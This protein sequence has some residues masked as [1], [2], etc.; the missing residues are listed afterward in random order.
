MRL[1]EFIQPKTITEALKLQS[2]EDMRQVYDFIIE[3][4]SVF[5]NE[6][7]SV[8]KLLYRG[9]QYDKNPKGFISQ[10]K[11]RQQT[12]SGDRITGLIDEYLKEQGFIA[13]RSN[14][15]F[16]TSDTWMVSDFG[17]KYAIFP[18]NNSAFTWSPTCKDLP[19]ALVELF[20]RNMLF[21][22]D[23]AKN[24]DITENKIIDFLKLVTFKDTDF[25]SALESGHE[26]LI[27]GQY[28][29]LGVDRHFDKLG[30][31][32]HR[33]LAERLLDENFNPKTFWPATKV[34]KNYIKQLQKDP[35]SIKYFDN[36]TEEEELVAVMSDGTSIQFIQNPSLKVQ[37]AAIKNDITSLSYIKNPNEKIKQL[38]RNLNKNADYYLGDL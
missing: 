20:D 15:L 2:S 25:D 18:F 16:T 29:A 26:I 31:N 4:C 11:V 37:A 13:L 34:N 38:A 23:M 9:I 35:F 33:E 30:E 6:M 12:N 28:V 21:V 10:S 17:A 7:R 22:G 3:N 8:N 19:I 32:P 5:L 27:N 14:S 24:E 1:F 36:P